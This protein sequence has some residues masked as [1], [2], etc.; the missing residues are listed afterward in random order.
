MGARILLVNG[1]VQ[2]ADNVTHIVANQLIDLT[3]DLH[4]LSEDAQFD[5]LKGAVARAD[6]VHRPIPERKGPPARSS[7]RHPR[8]ARII[9]P[10]RDFH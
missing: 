7:H 4:L 8:D 9:P 2:T 1:R 3:S 6:E 5:P 10:S